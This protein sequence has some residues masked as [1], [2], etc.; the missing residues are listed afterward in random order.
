MGGRMRVLHVMTVPASLSFLR[1]HS[2]PMRAGGYELVAATGP[3]PS[4]ARFRAAEGMP[5]HEFPIERKV[6][7]RSDPRAVLA[8]TK[9]IREVRPTFVHASTPKGGLIGVTAAR[10]ARVPVI[11]TMRGMPLL[12][13]QGTTA[14]LLWAAEAWSCRAAD[15]VI[16]VSD[17]L[18]AAAVERRVVSARRAHVLGAGSGQ[19][20]DTARFHPAPGERDALRAE[21]ALPADAVVFVFVGRFAADKGV[22]ELAA[23]FS[24]LAAS[25]PQAHL[26]LVGEADARDPAGA[27]LDPL[28][29][30]PRAHFLGFRDDVERIFRAADVLVFP[31]HREG[32]P[33]VP[34][35]AGATGL[36]TI[37]ARAVGSVDAVVDEHTGFLVPVGDA[38]A[39][40]RAMRRYL[41]APGLRA[42]HGAR[43]REHV[44]THFERGAVLA[45]LREFY[46]GFVARHR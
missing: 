1:G 21:L 5:V 20:V 28:R 9:I 13:A 43:A 32:F 26:L 22:A 3:G 37:A 44:Q 15:A 33:N 24:E 38:A 27:Q 25:S 39:L 8:L 40:A 19:G 17:S 46:D 2:A 11:Y 36:P 16:C 30:H 35:E 45:N 23:A 12:T 14:K 6:S 10:L 18:R 29:D 41:D 42:E 31:S 34:L 4:A 7:P